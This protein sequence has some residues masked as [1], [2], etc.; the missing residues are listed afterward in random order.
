MTHSETPMSNRTQGARFAQRVATIGHLTALYGVVAVL[1]LIGGLKFTAIEAEAV[2]PLISSTPLLEWMYSI[3]S[4]QQASNALGVIEICAGLLLAAAPWSPR[5]GV[6]GGV[7][8]SLT[9]LITASLLLTVPSWEAALG[10]FPALNP[11][12]SFLIKDIVLLG[13]VIG[14]TGKS[15]LQSRSR[16]PGRLATSA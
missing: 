8:G 15:L 4:A 13:A 9:F 12:G 5:A 14:I 6:A 11:I 3:M 1:L 7:L 16:H 10:G 2:R